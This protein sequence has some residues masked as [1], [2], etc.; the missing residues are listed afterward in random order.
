MNNVLRLIGRT[1][2]V[3]IVLVITS[4]LTPGFTIVG[5]WS[6]ILAAL[7]ISALDYFVEMMMSEKVSPF[8]NG[9]KGFLIS[10]VIIYVAQFFVPFM[11]VSIV[12]AIVSAVIIG[13][14]DAIFPIKVLS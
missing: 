9:V 6:Y 14:L 13:V 8:G 2:V 1:I 5:M 4:Y 3:A 12:G 7:V 11:A 10:A